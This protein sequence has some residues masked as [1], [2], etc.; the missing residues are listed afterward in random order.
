MSHIPGEDRARVVADPETISAVYTLLK[1]MGGWG[2]TRFGSHG[3]V[4]GLVVADLSK[5]QKKFPTI[6]FK[7]T[8]GEDTFMVEFRTKGSASWHPSYEG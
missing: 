3:Y 8:A 6:E 2:S 5:I 4:S 7:I 1:D